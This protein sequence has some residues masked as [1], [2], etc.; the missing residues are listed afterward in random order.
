MDFADLES[1]T[2]NELVQIAKKFTVYYIT[3]SGEGSTSNYNSLSKSQLID[4]ILNDKDYQ[5]ATG[6]LSRVERLRR[7]I[8]NITDPDQIMDAI[9][10]IFGVNGSAIAPGNYYT[11]IYNAKT[12]DLLYDQHPLIACLGTTENGFYG[13]NFHLN[14]NRNYTYPEVGSNVCHIRQNEIS[15]FRT[16]VYRKL[17]YS[18][19]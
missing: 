5:K 10:S 17:L 15:Y 18:G 13:L 6:T 19:R 3:K 9:L 2:K 8:V 12:P 16:L 14:M 1:K 11:Y 7:A 4:V